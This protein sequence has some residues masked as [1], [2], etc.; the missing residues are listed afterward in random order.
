[1]P[2]PFALSA[3]KILHKKAS[4]TKIMDN[5]IPDSTM[6][7]PD[8]GSAKSSTGIPAPARKARLMLEERP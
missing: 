6:I 3:V 8:K 4:A 7:T 5:R 1:M 2:I